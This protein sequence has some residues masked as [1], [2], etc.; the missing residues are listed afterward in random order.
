MQGG[1]GLAGT[2]DYL[3]IYAYA[4]VCFISVTILYDMS[5]SI[6]KCTVYMSPEVLYKPHCHGNR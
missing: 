4:H 1:W 5:S 2:S 3:L 6:D